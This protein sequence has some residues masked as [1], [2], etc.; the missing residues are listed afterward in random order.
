MITR[1][2][3]KIDIP[4][5]W[6]QTDEKNP[7]YF[8][9]PDGA[10]GIYVSSHEKNDIDGDRKVAE[11]VRKIERTKTKSMKGYKFRSYV[12]SVSLMGDSI[13]GH[14]DGYD[15]NNNYRIASKFIVKQQK[16]FRAALHD[17]DCTEY[18]ASKRAFDGIL[19]SFK[20]F[21][22]YSRKPTDDGKSEFEN[23]AKVSKEEGFVDIDLHI[24]SHTANKDG[25]FLI[26]VA[27]K[28]EGSEVGFKILLDNKWKPKKIANSKSSFF[29][30]T[31]KFISTGKPTEN[32]V[33]VLATL[34]GIS[35]PDFSMNQVN[36]EIV[37]L[38]NDP[39]KL[40]TRDTKMKI[41]L[42]SNNQELYSEVFINVNL[43]ENT[44]EFHEKDEEYRQPLIR[45]LCGEI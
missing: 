18:E 28:L 24:V 39:R 16:I 34:Y 19:D 2:Q 41:F 44:L 12:D 10:R 4:D 42:N 40:A 15:P 22:K 20:Y 38:A 33:E 9:S 45:S 13:V 11:F 32:F 1:D 25:S 5:N 6:K 21:P 43:A 36:I 26:K 27:N 17:Y 31:G 37:G 29:W 8:E 35:V 3:S 14:L 7:D 30:G 23:D